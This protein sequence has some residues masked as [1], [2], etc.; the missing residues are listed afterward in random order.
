MTIVYS[1]KGVIGYPLTLRGL[2]RVK[3]RATFVSSHADRLQFRREKSC[4]R[5]PTIGFLSLIK[6]Q[7]V[8]PVLDNPDDTPSVYITFISKKWR[9]L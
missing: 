8:Q 1:T 7:V 5:R 9:V 4:V 6:A 3:Q 2:S